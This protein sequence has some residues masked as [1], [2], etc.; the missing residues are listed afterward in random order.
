ML[1][2]REQALL[3]ELA[4]LRDL[5]AVL[6]N[7][8]LQPL[9]PRLRGRDEIGELLLRPARG[10]AEVR[11]IIAE[12]G[13]GRSRPVRGL[14]GAR[15]RGA[16]LGRRGG[17]GLE[18]L[19]GE[20]PGLRLQ[21]LR[22]VARALGG[23]GQGMDP[24]AGHDR[25]VA[26][27]ERRVAHAGDRGHALRQVAQE[28]GPFAGDGGD[29]GQKAR[30]DRL[31]DCVQRRAEGGGAG[32]HPLPDA[33]R[34]AAHDL[35]G[36]AEA[37]HG[38]DRLRHPIGELAHRDHGDAEPGAD[39]G[40]AGGDE[41]CDERP[42]RAGG[43]D[44]GRRHG[45]GERRGRR[46]GVDRQPVDV[47]RHRA[48]NRADPVDHAAEKP[49]L[50]HGSGEGHGHGLDRGGELGRDPVAGGRDGCG[51]L[52]ER[53]VGVA[54][55]GHRIIAEDRAEVGRLIPEP[56]H[57]GAIVPQKGEEQRRV[58]GDGLHIKGHL[59]LRDARLLEA[60][61]IELQRLGPRQVA[62]LLRRDAHLR[63]DL[64]EEV[65]HLAAA[66]REEI[67]HLVVHVLQDV[68]EL[69]LL[70]ADALRGGRPA[71]QRPGRGV[72]NLRQ[73][74]DLVRRA[75]GRHDDAGHGGADGGTDG[76][77]RAEGL[78]RRPERGLRLLQALLELCAVEAEVDPEC[79]DDCRH[80]KP[81]HGEGRPEA[82]WSVAIGGDHPRALSAMPM[83]RPRTRSWSAS[84]PVSGFR[85]G[86]GADAS[87]GGL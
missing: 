43:D 75:G 53:E 15:H 5:L 29:H 82:A 57:L 52:P 83:S 24:G 63:R 79:A 42:G 9:L 54:E 7:R 33:P 11:H 49:A 30:L 2:R 62:E 58:V 76:R 46:C 50:A 71:L 72:G 38:L 77:Q 81:P 19:G 41:A 78:G 55:R 68:G 74:R 36:V 44:Q 67:A 66:G 45:D 47:V 39:Q 23:R 65:L 59:R 69:L 18:A 3:R 61:D 26:H 86:G 8:R 1:V 85:A 34:D 10:G 64:L 40:R 6:L 37:A 28:V 12:V 27:I 14:P 22:L 25:H 20:R 4:E 48:C 51:H 31:P 17:G 73:P 87:A 32:L 70:D 16:Q 60:R 21:R 56:L 80:G 84:Q 35:H 13:D